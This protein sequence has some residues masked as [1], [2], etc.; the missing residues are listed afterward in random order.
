MK[1][2]AVLVLVLAAI[3]LSTTAQSGER[4]VTERDILTLAQMCV[5]EMN[6]RGG[7]TLECPAA[8][9][10]VLWLQKNR[11]RGR[12]ARP[13]SLTWVAQAYSAVWGG[14]HARRQ[15]P[16]IFELNL[17]GTRPSSW[18][19][20]ARAAWDPHEP[21]WVETIESVRGSVSLEIPNPCPGAHDWGSEADGAPGPRSVRVVCT[22]DFQ[23]E[24]RRKKPNVFW[25]LP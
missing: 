5:G 1:Y 6:W 24:G 21:R 7:E 14:P 15:R 8:V 20:T 4:P 10:V 9:H 17:E 19:A 23:Y 2:V 13:P 22:T 12:G 3:P 11:L 25:T 16:W 18:G